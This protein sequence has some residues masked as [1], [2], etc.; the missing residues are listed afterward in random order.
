[1]R[2]THD[3][4]MSSKV[5][6]EQNCGDDD[7]MDVFA[8]KLLEHMAKDHGTSSGFHERTQTKVELLM[9]EIESRFKVE[10]ESNGDW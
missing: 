5:W 7:P 1:M 6:A 3:D 2:L 4:I 9:A 8:H 10:D